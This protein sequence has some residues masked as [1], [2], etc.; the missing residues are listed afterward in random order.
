MPPGI[1]YCLMNVMLDRSMLGG[2]FMKV[3]ESILK[4]LA[5]GSGFS[6]FFLNF[7]GQRDCLH[8]LVVTI[9]SDNGNIT[10]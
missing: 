3:P 7:A 1:E 9:L 8:A 2:I 10:W 4:K 5:N 6:V